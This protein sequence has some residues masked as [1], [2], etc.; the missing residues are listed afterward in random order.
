MSDDSISWAGE[1]F[2]LSGTALAL[3][4]MLDFKFMLWLK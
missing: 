1:F 4:S 3:R 2:A